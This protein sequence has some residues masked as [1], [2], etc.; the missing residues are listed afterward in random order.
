MLKSK[1]I[2]TIVLNSYSS[3]A[4]LNFSLLIIICLFPVLAY[5]QPTF[6]YEFIRSI[7]VEATF[8]TTDK[9]QQIYYVTLQNQLIKLTSEGQQQFDFT[10][11]TL[12]D[13][14]FVDATDPFNILL[15][16]PDYFTL[17]FLDR[18]LNR[19]EEVALLNSGLQQTQAVGVS[20]DNQIWIYDATTF[21]LKKLNPQGEVT[22][23]SGDLNLLLGRRIEPNFIIERGSFVFVNAP[24]VGVLVFDLFGQYVKTIDI[25]GLERFQVINQQL[26]YMENGELHAFHLKALLDKIIPLPPLTEAPRQVHIQTNQLYILL[27]N[28]V[29]IYRF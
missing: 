27:D 18:T 8:F 4:G 3:A 29:D 15:F 11:K 26:L 12:G 22:L 2:K 1:A 28:R 5:S 16:Y 14:G 24:S 23:Q 7:P 6:Q 13:L 21:Q 17:L 20:A 9:L 19:T 10:N 25:Q